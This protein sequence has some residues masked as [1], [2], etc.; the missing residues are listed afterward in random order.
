MSVSM[1]GPFMGGFKEVSFF[2]FFFF[3]APATGCDSE[4]SMPYFAQ[5]WLIS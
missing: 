5:V 3:S 4:G 2:L 1:F